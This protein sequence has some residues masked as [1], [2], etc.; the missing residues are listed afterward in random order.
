MKLIEVNGRTV[1]EAVDSA[2]KELNVTKDKVEIEILDEGNKGF[3]NIFGAKPARIKVKVKRDYIVEAKSFLRNVLNSMEIKAEIR[4][5]EEDD[6]LNINLIGPNMGLIIGY[7]GETL[8]SLQYLIS[9]VVNKGHENPYKRVVLDTENYRAKRE[10]TLKRLAG[11]TAFKVRK[12]KKAIKLEPMNPYERRIIHA[13]L[14]NDKSVYT[15]SEG[16]EPFRKIV[17][18]F[19]RD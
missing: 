3:L 14:Q 11:K 6:T 7:R 15:Y 12:F 1:D 4:M 17:I 5:K 10:E 9:L 8:D 2:L 19:K 16:E 18:D 13:A